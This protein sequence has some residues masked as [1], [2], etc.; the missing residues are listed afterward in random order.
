MNE[1]SKEC[2]NCGMLNDPTSI[3]CVLCGRAFN[4]QKSGGLPTTEYRM[5]T[6]EKS[7]TVRSKRRNPGSSSGGWIDGTGLSTADNKFMGWANLEDGAEQL[8]EEDAFETE[9][10]DFSPIIEE[11][12]IS[13]NA[14][15]ERAEV[16][17]N[18]KKCGRKLYNTQY[19]PEVQ[20]YLEYHEIT[21]NFHKY[22]KKGILLLC[23]RCLNLKLIEFEK[24]R[25]R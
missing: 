3:N 6:P 5:G 24:R 11:N 23:P 25:L 22:F 2:P 17:G 9:K 4:A 8:D 14:E 18:C 7:A 12:V 15:A 16:I 21:D 19:Q 10:S 13:Q 1:Q 20:K